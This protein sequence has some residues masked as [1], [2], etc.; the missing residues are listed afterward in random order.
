MLEFG[1]SLPQAFEFAVG[2]GNQFFVEYDV[3]SI[4]CETVDWHHILQAPPQ[5]VAQEKVVVL[6][7]GGNDLF[8]T[9]KRPFD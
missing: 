9:S 6:R 4:R 1:D 8:V 7:I 3:Q 2:V 5:H